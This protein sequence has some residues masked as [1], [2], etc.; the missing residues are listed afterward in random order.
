MLGASRRRAVSSARAL[1]ARS[2]RWAAGRRA[3]DAAVAGLIVAR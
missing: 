2:R 3:L 1:H